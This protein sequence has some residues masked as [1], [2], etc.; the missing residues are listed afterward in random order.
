MRRGLGFGRG[1]RWTAHR[2]RA[3]AGLRPEVEDGTDMWG[4]A[5][6]VGGDRV[7]YR[8]GNPS[9]VGRGPNLR[10]GRFGSPGLFSIFLYFFFLFLFLICICFI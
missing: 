2:R 9:G 10:L 5:I 6:S 7:P 1:R 3:W 8:F 4:Q